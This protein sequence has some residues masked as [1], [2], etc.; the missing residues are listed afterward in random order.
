MADSDYDLFI[1]LGQSNA[2]GYVES[3][4]TDL[5]DFSSGGSF[6]D[7]PSGNTYSSGDIRDWDGTSWRDVVVAPNQSTGAGLIGGEQDNYVSS[8][9]PG[10]DYSGDPANGGFQ[11]PFI[12]KWLET[13]PT[14]KALVVQYAPGGSGI[15]SGVTYT[16]GNWTYNI[17]ADAMTVIEAAMDAATTA[18]YDYRLRAVIWCQGES[19][20]AAMNNSTYTSLTAYE[21]TLS[22]FVD[23]LWARYGS[24]GTY[25]SVYDDR[26]GNGQFFNIV[27]PAAGSLTTGI[28]DTFNRQLPEPDTLGHGHIRQACANVGADNSHAQV[29]AWNKFRYIDG[30]HWGTPPGVHW[31]QAAHNEI[32]ANIAVALISGTPPATSI[33]APSSVSA[34]NIG[35]MNLDLTW[36]AGGATAYQQRIE[37]KLSTDSEYSHVGCVAATDTTATIAFSFQ[38]GSTYNIRVGSERPDGSGIDWSTAASAAIP[39]QDISDSD[40]SAYTTAASDVSTDAATHIKQR[41]AALT[42]AGVG[43]GDGLKHLYVLRTDYN[44]NSGSTLYDVVRNGDLTIVGSP[45]RAADYYTFGSP[46]DY[47]TGVAKE[48]FAAAGPLTVFAIGDPDTP[49]GNRGLYTHDIAL[50]SGHAYFTAAGALVATDPASF[51]YRSNLSL[52]VN[53]A[54]AG[55]LSSWAVVHDYTLDFSANTTISQYKAGSSSGTVPSTV[56]RLGG[57]IYP[58]SGTPNWLRRQGTGTFGLAGDWSIF[59]VW[60]RALSGSEYAAAHTILLDLATGTAAGEGGATIKYGVDTGVDGY[61]GQQVGSQVGA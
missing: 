50:T 7:P 38:P 61:V 33:T 30:D 28:T 16:N 13:Y 29:V 35:R 22:G 4:S 10:H 47:L 21:T 43:I 56:K 40:I 59:A 18:G 34:S 6:I 45:T 57:Q 2:Q 17:L 12:D 58:S 3:S 51:P 1:I 53:S 25:G 8:V 27:E 11:N 14:K 42:T 49:A 5:I 20:A 15:V 24:S 60:D 19:D 9:E 26:S 32:G 37:C 55:A 46:G 52:T 36:T 44:A 31:S 23:T 39:A 48:S 54:I 41:L